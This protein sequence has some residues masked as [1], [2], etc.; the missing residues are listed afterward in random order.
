MGSEM[1]IR[2]R[3]S[4]ETLEVD[5]AVYDTRRRAIALYFLD[6]DKGGRVQEVELLDGTGAVRDRFTVEQF[7]NGKY[8]V[9][10]LKGYT[11]IRIRRISGQNAVLNGIFFDP[12]PAPVNAGTPVPLGN[13]SIS[14]GRVKLTATGFEDERFCLDASTDLK[15]WSCVL[16]NTFTTQT[17]E[18]EIAVDP[19][20]SHFHRAH[21][22]P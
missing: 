19:G 13:A 1:C 10:G 18:F 17:M 6:W 5:L 20:P 7:A 12:V 15:T 8:L 3:Y 22:V 2:D 16:T 14:N 11:K 21:I 9:I 4:A